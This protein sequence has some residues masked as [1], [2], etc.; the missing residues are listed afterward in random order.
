MAVA[1]KERISAKNAAHQELPN[2]TVPDIWAARSSIVS[3][4]RTDI[5]KKVA[6]PVK[7]DKAIKELDCALPG[8]YTKIIYDKLSKNDV[9]II[10]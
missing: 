7:A 2:V 3:C 10:A 1:L 5:M 9:V 6:L 4:L 8:P